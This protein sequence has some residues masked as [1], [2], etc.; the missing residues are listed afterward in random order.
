MAI[1]V[2]CAIRLQNSKACEIAQPT[3]TGDPLGPLQCD[4][5]SRHYFASRSDFTIFSSF[6]SDSCPT[7]GGYGPGEHRGPFTSMS[8]PMRNCMAS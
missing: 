1:C 8:G 6:G 4:T 3:G 7:L 5:C 2:P